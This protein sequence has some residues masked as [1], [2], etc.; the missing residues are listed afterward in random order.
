MNSL[1][2]IAFGGGCHWCT[3]AIFKSL[4][5]VHSVDQGFVAS[6]GTNKT[7]SEAVVIHFDQ[8]VITLKDLTA[9]H[10]HTHNSTSNHSM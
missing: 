6:D 7:F 9:I 10:L 5:G 8:S 3:E 1:Q 2:K 4:K